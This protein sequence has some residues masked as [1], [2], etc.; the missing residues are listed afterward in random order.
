MEQKPGDQAQLSRPKTVQLFKFRG[1]KPD[2]WVTDQQQ[3]TQIIV[4]IYTGTI[5]IRNIRNQHSWTASTATAWGGGLAKGYFG[6]EEM[7]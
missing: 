2:L 1:G 7:R 3:R 6:R 5:C 4:R